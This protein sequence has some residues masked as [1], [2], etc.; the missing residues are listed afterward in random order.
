MQIS[1]KLRTIRAGAAKALFVA[2]FI[3]LVTGCT[4]GR[5]S[6]F[7][8]ADDKYRMKPGTIAVVAG[9]ESRFDL[10]LAAAVSRELAA[11]G[12]LSVKSQKDVQAALSDYPSTI[13]TVK[14]DSDACWQSPLCL[15][16]GDAGRVA[17]I[18][19]QLGT[20]YLLVIW[21]T[22]LTRNTRVGMSGL[23]MSVK[24]T[25]NFYARLFEF[26][27]RKIVGY[28]DFYDYIEADRNSAFST[29]H[30]ADKTIAQLIH[31]AAK[32]IVGDLLDASALHKQTAARK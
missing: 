29:G 24:Y 17:A 5:P 10:Q 13:I 9:R 14:E 15:G 31:E 8:L 19:K 20:D 12:R 32:N 22:D 18:Q 4:G 27:S 11:R 21:G 30:D 7:W 2:S 16:A 1:S 3:L 23:S 25:S 6:S 26:P 28:S